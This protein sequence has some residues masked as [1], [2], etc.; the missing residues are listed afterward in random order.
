[1]EK[2]TYRKWTAEEDQLLVSQIR[3]T[4]Y[5]LHHCFLT[6]GAAIDRSATAVA[7]RWYTHTSRQPGNAAI[8]VLTPVSKCLNRKN[9]RGNTSRSGMFWRVLKLLRF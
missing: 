6:V 2:K 4:P 9:S 7:S 1:M 8:I 5:N 3:K